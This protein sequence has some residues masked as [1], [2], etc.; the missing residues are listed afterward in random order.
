MT[1]RDWGTTHDDSPA[2]RSED[3][4]VLRGDDTA[5]KLAL[6]EEREGDLDERMVPEILDLLERGGDPA[7]LAAAAI[8]LGPTLEMCDDEVDEDGVF[9]DDSYGAP[10]DAATY[11]R[12]LE[13]LRRLHSDPNA[14][15]LVRR[16]A[17]E[18]SVQSPQ[19][20]HAEAITAAWRSDEIDWRITAVF[21]MG[22]DYLDDFSTEIAEA[23]LTDIPQ[24]RF[25]A[26][27]AAGLRSLVQLLPEILPIATDDLAP[28][29][30]RYVAIETLAMLGGPDAREAIEQVAGS[31]DG[32]LSE[33]AVEML[34]EMSSF[35]IDDLD[36]LDDLDD[37]DDIEGLEDLEE[38]DSELW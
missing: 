24:L 28:I 13:V 14:P 34:E 8:A 19:D 22:F 6:F 20:W 5:A 9:H 36:G 27:R 30:H 11:W 16:R 7:V 10:V 4:A 23:L 18:A 12:M 25:E 26:I 1:T 38:D 33:F 37:L 21:C 3:A 32:D 31:D 29:D 17:L 15:L 2:S 35:A